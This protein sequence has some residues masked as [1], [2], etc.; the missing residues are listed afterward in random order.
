MVP[1]LRAAMSALKSTVG[2]C[3]A[4][5]VPPGGRGGSSLWL[6]PRPRMPA[7][8]GAFFGHTGQMQWS[9]VLISA[10]VAAVVGLCTTLALEFFAKPHLEA[11]KERVLERLRER[12]EFAALCREFAYL[13]VLERE[14]QDIPRYHELRGQLSR[15]ALVPGPRGKAEQV[16][17]ARLSVFLR[18]DLV[19]IPSTP[20]ALRN[21]VKFELAGICLRLAEL[22]NAPRTAYFIRRRAVRD[23]ADGLERFGSALKEAVVTLAGEVRIE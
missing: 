13:M 12:R 8:R 1:H 20:E 16:W 5:R 21:V 18:L 14:E 15:H 22:L 3:E 19:P 10:G 17:S 6:R 11:R 2:S 9:T 7:A 23:G 4:Q